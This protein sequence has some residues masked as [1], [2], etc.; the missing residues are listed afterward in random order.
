MFS[1]SI[2]NWVHQYNNSGSS[3]GGPAAFFN[4]INTTYPNRLKYVCHPLSNNAEDNTLYWVIMEESTTR[5]SGNKTIAVGDDTGFLAA[6]NIRTTKQTGYWP[7]G[8]YL[9]KLF[10]IRKKTNS[11]SDVYFDMYQYSSATGAIITPPSDSNIGSVVINNKYPNTRCNAGYVYNGTLYIALNG[12]ANSTQTLQTYVYPSASA[13][14]TEMSLRRD[15]FFLS[16]DN[17]GNRKYLMGWNGNTSNSHAMNYGIYQSTSLTGI[18]ESSSGVTTIAASQIPYGPGYDTYWL[19]QNHF[20]SGGNL[21]LRT[22][23]HNV[24][25]NAYKIEFNS[26]LTSASI[27]Q[28]YVTVPSDKSTVLFHISDYVLFESPYRMW[29]LDTS[30][31]IVSADIDLS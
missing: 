14:L 8:Y 4:Y 28:K 29:Y 20:A 25:T 11:A 19:Y 16:C 15:V 30:N 21:I 23:D 6:L 12:M 17:S 26:D 5:Y 7:L 13:S 9:D 3:A 10:V 22:T 2:A 31:N 27:G 24:G 18:H 1:N